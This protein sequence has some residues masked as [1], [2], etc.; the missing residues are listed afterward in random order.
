MT[1]T[2]QNR[3]EIDKVKELIKIKVKA[4]TH[5][6]HQCSSLKEELTTCIIN[7]KQ[8]FY[9]IISHTFKNINN[10]EKKHNNTLQ[11][12]K[13][14]VRHTSQLTTIIDGYSHQFHFMEKDRKR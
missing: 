12:L 1:Y 9:K 6:A 11:K 7:Q 4:D 3:N 8:K 14:Q 13:E 10:F 2:K 5:V